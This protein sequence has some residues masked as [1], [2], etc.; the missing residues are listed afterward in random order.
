[1]NQRDEVL[2][3][4]YRGRKFDYEEE[5]ELSIAEYTKCINR[6]SL[7]VHGYFARGTARINDLQYWEAIKDFN[8]VL[9]LSPDFGT[10]YFYRAFARM[11]KYR[12][13][14]FSDT[15]T[16][17][18]FET[19]TYLTPP[20]RVYEGRSLTIAEK[21]VV[22]KDFEKGLHFS[23]EKTAVVEVLRTFCETEQD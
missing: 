10:A 17:E 16:V 9:E 2:T 21:E 19:R 15:T 11:K 7:F 1:M 8:K 6:D 13:S 14:K 3:H 4:F 20:N 5:Y 23:S 18:H 22:C 12:F